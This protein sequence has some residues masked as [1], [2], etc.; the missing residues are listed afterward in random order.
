MK[1]AGSSRK[2]GMTL[3]GP[4]YKVSVTV[5]KPGD[6]PIVEVKE[7]KSGE[8][9]TQTRNVPVLRGITSL[10]LNNGPIA[11]ALALDLLTEIQMARGKKPVVLPLLSTALSGF[12]IYRIFGNVSR[13]R[14]FHGA[15]HKVIG[16]QDLGLPNDLEHVKETSRISDRC[17]TNFV[18]FYVPA[19]MVTALLPLPSET[20]KAV[21]AM[22]LAYEGFKLDRKKYGKYVEPFYRLGAKA[23]KYATTAEP[24]KEEMD[25][26]IAAMQALLKAEKEWQEA[27]AADAAAQ[28]A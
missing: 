2:D 27:H 13:L 3:Y 17:G 4:H 18:G 7:H 14:R 21:L 25:A 10:V 11:G 9:V 24:E 1:I 15:E 6:E 26:A 5:P 22:G 12:M 23:Q 28:P 8:A 19:Q 20:L 16:T